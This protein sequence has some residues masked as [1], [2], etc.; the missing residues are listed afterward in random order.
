ME[1][2]I[3][4]GEQETDNSKTAR[5]T[6]GQLHPEIRVNNVFEQSTPVEIQTDEIPGGRKYSLLIEEPLRSSDLRKILESSSDQKYEHQIA[7]SYLRDDID[8][9]GGR[10]KSYLHEMGRLLDM[11]DDTAFVN[12]LLRSFDSHKEIWRNTVGSQG[13]A[14]VL[15]RDF[16][17][18][19]SPYFATA[20]FVVDYLSSKRSPLTESD[21]IN[22]NRRMLVERFGKL[23]LPQRLT[24]IDTEMSQFGDE[25]EEEQTL[26]IKDIKG[27]NF[28]IE[29]EGEKWH[30]TGKWDEIVGYYPKNTYAIRRGYDAAIISHSSNGFT[31]SPNSEFLVPA[32]AWKIDSNGRSLIIPSSFGKNVL[33]RHVKGKP[34]LSLSYQLSER[35]KSNSVAG[36]TV[37]QYVLGYQEAAGIPPEHIPEMA[38]LRRRELLRS[39]FI[40]KAEDLVK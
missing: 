28:S 22:L 7:V 31:I 15:I 6:L 25:Q 38:L 13:F 11:H 40:K 32:I 36:L 24:I 12:D 23:A 10:Q 29:H 21:R 33:T 2:D 16:D 3:I 27:L 37:L 14:Q 18:Y 26:R 1:F 20:K 5:T 9:F 30:L 8:E 34:S 17:I 39:G 35:H 4:H 19:N